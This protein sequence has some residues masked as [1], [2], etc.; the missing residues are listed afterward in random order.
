MTTA[1]G[2]HETH[3]EADGVHRGSACAARAVT[4]ALARHIGHQLVFGSPWV[5]VCIPRGAEYGGRGARAPRDMPSCG[6]RSYAVWKVLESAKAQPWSAVAERGTSGD[7]ALGTR[8]RWTTPAA[9]AGKPSEGG[10]AL[11]LPAA[12]QGARVF[13]GASSQ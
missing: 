3:D 11:S 8:V 10:V 1:L 5:S 2:I 9:P 12:L 7:T 4:R 13:P 6:R